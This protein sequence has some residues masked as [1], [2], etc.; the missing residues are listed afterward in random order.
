MLESMI[1]GA[2][3]I[4][5]DTLSTQEWITSGHNGLLVPPESPQ[6]VAAALR[7]ALADVDLVEQAA[8]INAR[9]ADERLGRDWIRGQV[10]SSYERAATT[11][12]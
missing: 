2:F 10:I 4:Q 9:I 6:Q 3:P 1:M 8:V 11:E 5:S 7:Q 12:R